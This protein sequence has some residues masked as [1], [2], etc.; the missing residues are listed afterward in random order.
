M[1]N[2]THSFV[3]LFNLGNDMRGSSSSSS[4]LPNPT[5]STNMTTETQW[6]CPI[7]CDSQDGI[8]YVTPCR[9]KFCLGCI[10]RWA[11]G[12]GSF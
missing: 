3:C 5:Q 7:C 11:E 9:H 10:L 4:A 6:S 8:A 12:L 2:A 1:P